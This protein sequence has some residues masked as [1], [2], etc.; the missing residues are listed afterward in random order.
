M[1]MARWV[2]GD[3]DEGR[4]EEGPPG[5]ARARARARETTDIYS[6]HAIGVGLPNPYSPRLKRVGPGAPAA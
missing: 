1:K 5:S 4:M 2:G 3:L 6:L